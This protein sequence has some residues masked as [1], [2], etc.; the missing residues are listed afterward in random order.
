MRNREIERWLEWAISDVEV[1][2]LAYND[3]HLS[4]SVFQSHECVEKLVKAIIQEQGNRFPYI[5]N[6]EELLSNVRLEKED[7]M[8]MSNIVIVLENLYPIA[9]YPTK[10]E[11]RKSDAKN[12][13]ELAKKALKIA[14]KY[15]K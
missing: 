5:H 14:K 6:V 9:R 2:E 1:A 11:I 13:L 7:M 8:F 4:Q 12:A 3:G 15:L 10:E